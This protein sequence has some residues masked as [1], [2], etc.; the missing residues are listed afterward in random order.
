MVIGYR[1]GLLI[2]Y[3]KRT[4]RTELARWI[5][6]LLALASM[7]ACN[8]A[9]D[10]PPSPPLRDLFDDLETAQLGG[11]AARLVAEPPA[12]RKRTVLQLDFESEGIEALV[13][14]GGFGAG[15]DVG[16][17]GATECF[18]A[19]RTAGSRCA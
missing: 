6:G 19:S 16:E 15:S 17:G 1:R 7:A 4:N 9:P 2:R 11:L 18:L 3:R 14:F 5:T 12:V 13:P 10:E 8:P